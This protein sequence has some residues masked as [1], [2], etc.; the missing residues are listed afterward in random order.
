METYRTW[1]T[2][3]DRLSLEELDSFVEKVREVAYPQLVQA[4]AN[5]LPGRP[6]KL[7]IDFELD[8]E[9]D[10]YDLAE[11][12]V[13]LS[14][15]LSMIYGRELIVIDRPVKMERAGEEKT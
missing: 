4:D 15:E 1:I 10:L 12:V 7:I 9:H 11:T 8:D 2:L 6:T 5:K 13:N 14:A 3:P